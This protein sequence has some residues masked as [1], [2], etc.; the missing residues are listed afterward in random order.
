MKLISSAV[1]A[2]TVLALASAT[3]GQD[4]ITGSNIDAVLQAASQQGEANLAAQPNGDPLINAE[5]GGVAYQIF[6]R[7]CTEGTDCED[8]NF[9]LGFLDNKPSLEQ[10]NAWNISKRFSRAYLDQDNDACVEMD[11]DLVQ[12]VSPAYLDAQVAIWRMVVTQF[13]E[14]VGYKATP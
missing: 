7:N 4:A 3:L 1:G 9:Y 11:L 14:H 10:I 8:L 12:G 6:F 2:I 13:A 5:I